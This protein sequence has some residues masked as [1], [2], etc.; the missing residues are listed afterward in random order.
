VTTRV[1]HVS[2]LH[3]GAHDRPEVEPALR[4]LIEDAEPAL[5]V[6][7]GDL[8]HRGRRDQ[9]ER[10]AQFL[11]SLGPP[12][13]AV[14]GNHDIPHTFPARFTS[15]FAEFERQWETSE[16]LFQTD[17]LVVVGL[18]SVR[19]WRHQSGGVGRRQLE[20]A[21]SLLGEAPAGAL[22]VVALHHQ[23]IGAPWRTRKRPV[24]RRGHVLAALFDAG[25]EL[26]LAGHVHQSSVG[27]R[28]EFVVGA[29][30]QHGVTIANAPGLG[31]PR[32][33]RRGEARGLH[34]YEAEPDAIHVRTHIWG[35]GR[36][37]LVGDRRFR[38][39]GAP[40]TPS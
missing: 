19:A 27:E 35:D 30:T 22:R 9:H 36:W 5:V 7:T 11:R 15:T 26:I 3:V 14:P 18:N 32:P 17:G 34:V 24:A 4:T 2:D 16:P 13:L 10:A 39:G 23:L 29:G 28:S 20:R 31:Q 21:A 38:R 33:R 6:A 25:A 37:A 8:T 1:V 40:L 12:V